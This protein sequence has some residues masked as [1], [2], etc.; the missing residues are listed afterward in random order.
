MSRAITSSAVTRYY[1][2][3]HIVY[4]NGNSDVTVPPYVRSFSLFLSLSAKLITNGKEIRRYEFLS[5]GKL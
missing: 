4:S 3:M 2:V 5:A 1:G